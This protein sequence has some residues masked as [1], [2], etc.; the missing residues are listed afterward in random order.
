MLVP[1]SD[2]TMAQTSIC[3]MAMKTTSER[4]ASKQGVFAES[5][6]DTYDIVVRQHHWEQQA[7]DDEEGA[8]EDAHVEEAAALVVAEWITLG[9]DSAEHQR[10]RRE[11]VGRG[12]CC[13]GD[14]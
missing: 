11:D 13:V 1:I 4:R 9:E 7:R 6:R 5:T 12:C 3:V 8:E 14:V 10:Q 2:M